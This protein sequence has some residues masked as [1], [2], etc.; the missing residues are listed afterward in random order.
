MEQGTNVERPGDRPRR[1]RWAVVAVVLLVVCSFLAMLGSGAALWLRSRGGQGGNSVDADIAAALAEERRAALRQMKVADF[2][3]LDQ[4]G[5]PVTARDLDGRYTVLSF[6]FTY[7]T[8]ACPMMSGNLYRVQQEAPAHVQI[9]SLSVDPAHDTP[10]RLAEYAADLGAVAPRWRM[11]SG[12]EKVVR[13]VA[14]SLGL[15]FFTDPSTLIDMGGGRTMANITHPTRFLLIGPDGHAIESYSGVDRT[16]VDRLI[17]D[18]RALP[19]PP[20]AGR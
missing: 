9:V 17:A 7:C 12:P 13:T 19:A 3:M 2:A 4:T 10:Q 8:L 16:D 18:L 6:M 15:T 11:L 1:V 5:Q 14:E 20:S